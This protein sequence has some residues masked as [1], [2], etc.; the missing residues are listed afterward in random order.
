MIVRNQK[1]Q[2]PVKKTSP[3]KPRPVRG[4]AGNA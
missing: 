1:R 3:A 2:Q 4:G